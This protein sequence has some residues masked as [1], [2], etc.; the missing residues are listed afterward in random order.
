MTAGKRMLTGLEKLIKNARNEID[1]LIN[2]RLETMHGKFIAVT[3]EEGEKTR[4]M[5][6]HYPQFLKT[7]AERRKPGKKKTLTLK[8]EEQDLQLE[9]DNAIEETTKQ[10]I[11]VMAIKA[12]T[13]TERYKKNRATNEKSEE[14]KKGH[15]KRKSEA[16]NEE[17]QSNNEKIKRESQKG[18]RKG[19]RMVSLANEIKH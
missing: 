9:Q 17:N 3:L 6:V 1:K 11:E 13:L 5:D 7:P 10:L 15:E 4:E 8:K 14:K 19:K 12:K 2:N 18:R 16:D